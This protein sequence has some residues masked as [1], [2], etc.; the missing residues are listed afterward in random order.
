MLVQ[1]TRRLD[2]GHLSR[3]LSK[4]YLSSKSSMNYVNVGCGNRFHPNWINLDLV[5]TGPG[6]LAHDLT[7]KW[8]LADASCEVVYHSHVLEHIRRPQVS[9]FMQECN[10]ILKPGGVIRVAV[11]DLE[12]ICQL[13]LKNLEGAFRGDTACQQNYDWMMLEMF[14]QV[15]R[16]RG[17]SEMRTYLFDKKMLQDPFVR[18]RIG[19]VHTQ[20]GANSNFEPSIMWRVG[21][22]FAYGLSWL[23]PVHAWRIGRFRLSG[24]VH[25]WMYDRYSLGQLLRTHGFDNPLKQS[26]NTSMIPNWATFNLDTLP[27]GAIYKP[28]SLFM[29]ATKLNPAG[30]K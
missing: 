27:D 14:D 21:K 30:L 11:P 16:E 29:E 19:D 15:V 17:A 8:P 6:V 1:T 23:K 12:T 24:E 4:P 26:A 18:S 25:Q 13:Y 22:K 28:D 20:I 10:R 2:I 7:R 9:F 5:A 3:K